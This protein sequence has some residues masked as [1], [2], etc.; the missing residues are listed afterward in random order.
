[1]GA[2]PAS[3]PL[4]EITVSRTA[5]PGSMATVPAETRTGVVNA[6]LPRLLVVVSRSALRQLFQRLLHSAVPHRLLSVDAD[7]VTPEPFGA[8]RNS[9]LVER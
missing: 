3:T 8:D 1:M 5:A 7:A 2:Q 9:G 4:V 6:W